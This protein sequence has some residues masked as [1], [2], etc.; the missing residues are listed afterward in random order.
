MEQGFSPDELKII[1]PYNTPRKIQDFLD[2]LDMNFQ[3]GKPTCYSPRRVLRERKA[4][5]VEGALLA[6]AMLRVAGW[7][8]LVME[9]HAAAH[10]YD[11]VVAVFQTDKYWER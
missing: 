6:A 11:H 3:L 10:D 9:L 1:R 8:P 7:K 2:T 5:C 4:Q